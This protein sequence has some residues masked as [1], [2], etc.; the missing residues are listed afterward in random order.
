VTGDVSKDRTW[1]S[2]RLDEGEEEESEVMQEAR[3]GMGGMEREKEKTRGQD[4]DEEKMEKAAE[5][6]G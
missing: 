3:A 1:H 4:A 2:V 5:R 6:A